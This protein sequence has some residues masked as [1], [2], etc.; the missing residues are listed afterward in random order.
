MTTGNEKN[1]K[2]TNE[3]NT[4]KKTMHL[5]VIYQSSAA[6][7][8]TCMSVNHGSGLAVTFESKTKIP[9][10]STHS[11][12]TGVAMVTALGMREPVS[13]EKESAILS[14]FKLLNFVVGKMS[15]QL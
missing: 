7:V 14:F 10:V 11:P 15:F 8:S 1:N 2:Q 5:V 9:F 12:A 6:R 13:V 4:H 3:L